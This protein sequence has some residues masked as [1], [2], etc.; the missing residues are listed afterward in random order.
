MKGLEM[1]DDDSEN[2][3]VFQAITRP[4]AFKKAESSKGMK[5]PEPQTTKVRINVKLQ[6]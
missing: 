1:P 3:V 4:S 6:Q 2:E 5:P